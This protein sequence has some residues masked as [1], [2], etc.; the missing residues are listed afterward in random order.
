MNVGVAAC[1]A[2]KRSLN[3]F[4]SSIRNAQNFYACTNNFSRLCDLLRSTAFAY[5]PVADYEQVRNGY[6]RLRNLR[7]PKKGYSLRKRRPV[8]IGVTAL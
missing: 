2:E 8:R 5:D 3:D 6:M 1:V 4:H 7:S